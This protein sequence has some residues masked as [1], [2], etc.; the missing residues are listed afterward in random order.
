MKPK[1]YILVSFLVFTFSCTSQSERDETRLMNCLYS[2]IPDNGSELKQ[3]MLDFENLLINEKIIASNSGKS[4]IEMFERLANDS[5]LIIKL[6]QSFA[7]ILTNVSKPDF[8]AS[9]NCKSQILD[10]I[11]QN[12]SKI[13]GLRDILD[14]IDGNGNFESSE[15]AKGLISVLDDKDMELDYYKL[16]TFFMLDVIG[17][18][19]DSGISRQLPPIRDELP[20]D[21]S[22]ALFITIDSKDQVYVNEEIIQLQGLRK[23]VKSYVRSSK[24]NTVISLK[25]DLKAAYKTYITVQN[26]IVAAIGA[27]RE[28]LSQERYGLPFGELNEEQ[29][30]EIKDVYPSRITE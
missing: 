28:E 3:A 13:F 24:S 2:H 19:L 11:D 16:N 22:K 29:S 21:M 12:N 18:T 17:V 20:V 1:I 10:S 23:R 8:E 6:P 4:Y 30:K 7:S 26:E 27:L 25:P 9:E 14:D 15:F 5:T